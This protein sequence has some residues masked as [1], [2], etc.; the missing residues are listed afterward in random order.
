MAGSPF[1]LTFFCLGKIVFDILELLPT[2]TAMSLKVAKQA[3]LDNPGKCLSI[4]ELI[5]M[6]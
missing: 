3:I 5:A 6:L 1:H 2:A 4:N